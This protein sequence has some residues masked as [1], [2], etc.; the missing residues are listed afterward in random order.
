MLTIFNPLIQGLLYS[1][2]INTYKFALHIMKDP[3]TVYISG[4]MFDGEVKRLFPLGRFYEW[5]DND[6]RTIAKEYFD[7]FIISTS[8][9]AQWEDVAIRWLTKYKENGCISPINTSISTHQ[10]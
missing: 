2:N 9:D 4:F 8:F 3:H 10:D 6:R 7:K 5:V 1:R